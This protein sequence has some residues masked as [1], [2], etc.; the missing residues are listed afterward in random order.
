MS[1]ALDRFIPVLKQGCC[2]LG[3]GL[4]CVLLYE[5]V[6]QLGGFGVQRFEQEAAGLDGAR[7]RSL[8]WS[9]GSWELFVS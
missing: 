2:E 3:A 1:E 9:T 6:Y 8:V 4:F 7:N 5:I